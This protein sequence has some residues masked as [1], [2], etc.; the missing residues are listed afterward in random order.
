MIMFGVFVTLISFASAAESCILG[1]ELV[2]QD[3]YPA[4]PGDYVDLVFQ[5]TGLE[6]SACNGAVL[7]LLPSYPFSFY[8]N[9]TFNQLSGSTWISSQKTDW[10]VH[11]RLAVDEDA[12]E[13]NPEIIVKYGQEAPPISSR[14]FEI[15]VDDS[16]TEFDTVIQEVTGTDVSIAIANVGK[17]PANSVV[18]RIPQQENFRAS[19]TD[20]QMIGNLDSGDYTIVGFD[21]TRV[22]TMQ[23]NTQK[24]EGQRAEIQDIDQMLKFDI[25]YTDSIGERRIVNLELPLNMVGGNMTLAGGFAGRRPSQSSS[26]TNWYLVGFIIILVV[27]GIWWY[28]RKEK[29]GIRKVVDKHSSHLVPD[30]IRNEKKK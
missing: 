24:T 25:Y 5:V 12:F 7:E 11:Y 26:G 15:P 30:W 3:P 22:G 13:G 10:M 17:Y 2:N 14:K 8:G 27:V 9:T 18:V 16:R 1:V 6:N 19:G 23:R 21:I 28:K 29:K 4:V 20:G